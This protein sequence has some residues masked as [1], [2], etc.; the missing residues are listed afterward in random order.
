MWDDR[1]KIFVEVI[2]ERLHIDKYCKLVSDRGAGA[3]SSFIGT[4]RDNFDGK[5]VTRLEYEAYT[6]MAVKMLKEVCA[7]ACQQWDIMKIAVAHRLGEVGV[8]EASVIICVSSPHRRAALEACHWAIDELKAIVPIWKK[9][10]YADGHIW[11]ENAESRRLYM[12]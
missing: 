2:P 4:T 12:S 6:P 8:E 5:E 1:G 3:I 11:K 10:W 9:E 7:H